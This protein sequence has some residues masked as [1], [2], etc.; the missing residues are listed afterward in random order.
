MSNNNEDDD[1]NKKFS[2][3]MKLSNIEDFDSVVKSEM[4]K[5]IKEN[6]LLLN[7][8]NELSQEINAMI[9]AII[10]ESTMEITDD[11]QENLS[12]IYKLAI[13]FI[14]DMIDLN[15]IELELE[16]DSDIEFDLEEEDEEDNDD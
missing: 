6:I 5:S 2:E 3:I 8:L 1:F 13:D 7:V 11:M 10:N 4:F 9:L 16:F 14:D 12:T 15:S